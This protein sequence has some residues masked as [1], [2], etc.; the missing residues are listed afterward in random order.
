MRSARIAARGLPPQASMTAST[1]EKAY[2]IQLLQEMLEKGVE[3]GHVETKGQYR[4]IDTQE[5][6]ALA[7]KLWNG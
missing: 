6:M 1:S 2:L 5:D 7:E 3:I 4:E